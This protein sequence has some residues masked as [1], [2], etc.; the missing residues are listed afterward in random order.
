[1]FKHIVLSLAWLCPA[2]FCA[3][4]PAM[5]GAPGADHD[6]ARYVAQPQNWAAQAGN[7]QNWRH[8]ELQQINAYNVA[9]LQLA[10]QFPTGVTRGHEGGPLVI[11]DTLYLHTPYPNQVVAISLAD[12]QVKWRHEPQQDSGA[13]TSLCCDTVS[14][15]LGYGDGM[16]L[17]Q[18]TDTT[19]VAVDANTGAERWKVRNGDLAHGETATNAPHVFDHYV[20]TGMAGGEYGARGYITAYDLAT[21]RRVWRGYSTGPDAS[22]L[23][24]PE[25]TMTWS[26]GHMVPVG[27]DSSLKS[28]QGE[29]WKYGGGTTW[30]WYSYDPKLRLL[31]Y[32]SGNPSTWNPL[33]RPGDN[34]WS[35]ALWARDIDTGKV[36]WVYQMTPHDQWDYDGVNELVLFD[37]RDKGGRARP[38][39]AHFDRNGFAYTLDRA[40]GELLVAEKFDPSVNW[41]SHV[42][43][44]SGRPQ[45][46]PQFSPENVGEEETVKGICPATIG[47]KNQ[48]PA[49][50]AP[51]LG[52][53]LVP[54]NHLCMDE[55]IF[56]VK[57]AAGQP[58]TGA[59]VSIRPVPGDEAELGRFIAWDAIRGRIAWSKAE[60][61]PVWSGAL[62]TASGLVFYGTL[63]AY[64]KA[65][66]ART[67][68]ELW[69]SPKLPSGVVGNVA[70]W[71]Y[72]GRQYVGV[73]AGIGGL[74]N[75]P[76]GIARLADQKA[77]EP[78]RPSGGVLM[79]FALPE[80]RKTGQIEH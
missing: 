40:T 54:T 65:L 24:D 14:R 70:S 23:I 2:M 35:M 20:I 44:R 36:R 28:W 56:K 31:Y 57:Y 78:N 74:A 51:R 39:L 9:R 66:D 30:G 6:L 58:Y 45:V 61:F 1:M 34:K 13:L 72:R 42:D 69:V 15:G 29:Q 22:M 71:A 52:L 26:N 73:F 8:S 48:A 67:G 21:G 3:V 80:G 47:A 76:D 59:N 55:E 75:D 16:I 37:G 12:H 79:V 68:K 38:M 50:Y 5:S 33:L 18:Q 53:F 4:S 17:L 32:G 62:A 19:L 11:G 64:L 7:F 43:P 63:D 25:H 77:L 41:A 10:W 60:R 49:A 27:K 46:V